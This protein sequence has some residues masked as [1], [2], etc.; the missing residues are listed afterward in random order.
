[1]IRLVRDVAIEKTAI[2]QKLRVKTEAIFSDSPAVIRQGAYW[3][4]GPGQQLPRQ[5][6][7]RPRSLLAHGIATK[8]HCVPGLS[9][10]PGN[11][12]ADRQANLARDARG[13]TVI[14]PLFTSAS[15]MATQISEG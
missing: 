4:P 1:V 10:I 11:G 5:I 8:I 9:G 14:D 2:F 15:N 13:S 3:Q 12:K 6:S 7:R